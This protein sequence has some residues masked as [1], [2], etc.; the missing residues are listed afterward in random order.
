MLP[1]PVYVEVRGRL[2]MAADVIANFGEGRV[3]WSVSVWCWQF[4]TEMER[5]QVIIDQGGALSNSAESKL[6]FILL[7]FVS[8]TS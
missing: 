5:I 3:K 1:A 2:D 6:S 7:Y 8:S 4:K